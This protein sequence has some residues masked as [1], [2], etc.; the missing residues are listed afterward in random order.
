MFPKKRPTH[1][2]II[3]ISYFML[4]LFGFSVFIPIFAS[5]IS[6]SHYKYTT[7]TNYFQIKSRKNE[8]NFSLYGKIIYK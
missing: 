7:K 8:L 6:L 2:F 1:V 5:I 4:F 3:F